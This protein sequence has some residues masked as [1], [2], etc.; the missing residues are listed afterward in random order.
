VTSSQN[1]KARD[2][3]AFNF[4]QFTRV[5]NKIAKMSSGDVLKTLHRAGIVTKDGKLADKYKKKYRVA[6][7][8]PLGDRRTTQ[9][10]RA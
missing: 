4:G 8:Q 3:S 9:V 1:H 5:T 7:G 2:C 10:V 6:N